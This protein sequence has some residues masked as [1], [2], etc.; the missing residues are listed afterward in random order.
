MKKNAMRGGAYSAVMTAV[1]LAI[2][3]AV[4]VL[5]SALHGVRHQCQQALL[6]HQQHQE[7]GERADGGC[8]HLLDRPGRRGG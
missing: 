6:R 1:V 4:N 5:F 8:D 2:L 7:R 3:V